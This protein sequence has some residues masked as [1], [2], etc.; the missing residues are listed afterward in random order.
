MSDGL[1]G[2]AVGMAQLDLD[3]VQVPLHL[4]LDPDGLVPAPHLGVQGFPSSLLFSGSSFSAVRS[5]HLFG[6]LSI[7]F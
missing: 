2:L 5:L 7:D 1:R 4:L 3:F 6:H